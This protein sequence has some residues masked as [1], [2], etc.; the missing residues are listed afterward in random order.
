MN[1]TRML[2]PVLV[3][4]L[5]AVTAV[6]AADDDDP[7]VWS[8]TVEGGARGVN[9][10]GATVNGA[11]TTGAATAANAP[12]APVVGPSN[13]AGFTE[14][15]DLKSGGL[16]GNVDVLGSSNRNYF[17][18]YGENFGRDD[19]YLDARGGRYGVFKYQLFDDRMVHNLS[20][21]GLTPYLGAGSSNL[22]YPGVWS[23]N[24]TAPLSN[25][26]NWN[27][28][29]YKLKRENAGGNFE[30][31]NNSPWYIRTDVNQV[32]TK[33]VQPMSASFA[34]SGSPNFAYIELP[35]PV[36]YRTTNASL[37]AGYSVRQG[38]ISASILHSSFSNSDAALTWQDP[39]TAGGVVTSLLP[40]S[41][42]LTKV[43]INGTLRQLPL[44]STLMGRFSYSSLTD[45][46]APQG[47]NMGSTAGSAAT[48]N[49]PPT[50]SN[51]NGN[52]T[53]RSGSLSL[54]SN[55]ARG[56][57]SRLYGNYYE[58]NNQSTQIS[59]LNPPPST[60]VSLAALPNNPL[61]YRKLDGGIDVGFR[62]NPAHKL[63]VG[64]GWTETTRTAMGPAV[65]ANEPFLVPSTTKDISYYAEYKNSA[66]DTLTGRLKLEHV[67]RTSSGYP[68]IDGYT[69]PNPPVTSSANPQWFQP[70]NYAPFSRNNAKLFLDASPVPLLS[71]GFEAIVKYTSYTGEPYGMQSDKRQEYNINAS[72]GDATSFRVTAFGDWESIRYE[73]AWLA[74]KTTCSTLGVGLPGSA[75]FGGNFGYIQKSTNR[76]IGAG[77]DW[78]VKPKLTLNGSFIWSTTGGGVDFSNQILAGTPVLTGGNLPSY[79]TDNTTKHTINLKAKYEVDSHWSVTGGAAWER[80]VYRDDQ[81]NGFNG[82]YPY[83]MQLST[84]A[85]TNSTPIVV[86]SGAFQNPSY[87]A[88]VLYVKAAYKF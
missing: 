52:K 28:V 24:P 82:A 65:S 67:T 68:G 39:F 60:V 86:M 66:L 54:S 77:F 40:P 4:N 50:A 7:F 59:Y 74:C 22:T 73:D 43:G 72:Y 37:E 44:H 23:L 13:N 85:A 79:V 8:G 27:P 25:P 76:M 15:R 35:A 6:S 51:F 47:I 48:V 38:T 88:T 20:S 14:Y 32:T 78:A 61:G 70:L 56:L 36:N 1:T 2:I 31:T 12:S 80:Y 17:G 45:S 34:V 69:V 21:G 71:L 46:F 81:M 53:T 62:F 57:D 58:L 3:A 11:R 63:G 5:F 49:N 26:A 87:R 55:P 84:T 10:T 75:A 18:F 16:I 33:G 83:Y 29:D 64:W 30:L 19:Q 9:A 41:S 42:E